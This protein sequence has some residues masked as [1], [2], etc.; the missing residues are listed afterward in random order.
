V[1]KGVEKM[2]EEYLRK[3]RE[4]DEEIER[5]KES[6]EIIRIKQPPPEVLI[7][8]FSEADE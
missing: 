8:N 2:F 3:V 1:K 7:A 4:L 5:E 6:Q